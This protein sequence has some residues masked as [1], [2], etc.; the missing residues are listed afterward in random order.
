[1]Y[2]C[3]IINVQNMIL[4]ILLHNIDFSEIKGADNEDITSIVFDS[5]KSISGSLF[6]AIK[7]TVTDGHN[8]VQNA[9][10]SG[11]RAV[12]CERLP[13]I[14]ADGVTYVVVENSEKAVAELARAFYGDPSRKLKLVGVTGTNGKTTVA[15]LL[16][17][18]FRKLGYKV[19]LISTVVYKINDKDIASTHTTPDVVRLNG[20]FSEMVAEGC[21][22]CF[23]EVSSHSIVQKRV[24]SLDFDGAVFTNITHDHLDYHGTFVEYIR[25]KKELFDNLKKEAF[26]LYNCDDRNGEVMVQNCRAKKYSY[27]LSS[28][29]DFRCDVLESHFEGTLMEIDGQE[30]WSRLIGDFNAYNILS[31]YA[32]AKLLGVNREELLTNISSLTTVDGRFDY[33]T[34]PEGVTAIVDYAHTPDALQNVLITVNKIKSGSQKLICVVGC[35]GDRDKTKRPEMA[36]IAVKNSDFTIFTS[37]N[38][39]TEKPDDILAD[40]VVGVSGNGSFSSCYVTISDRLQAIKMASVMAKS[41][42]IILIAGKGHETYQDI[43]GVKNHFSDKEEISKLFNLIN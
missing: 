19:G 41:G 5:R 28:V 11:C 22:Y 1:M 20:M 21:E 9:V 40:M 6:V 13:E 23:M 17:Q 15:T 29:A 25:A 43:C 2:I 33:I 32:T 27:A 36:L 7:G 35:G 37:D 18:L 3:V 14:I 31:I 34:S 42:D 8:F 10:E 12:V 38:P 4:K 39:R 30:V 16:Y 26:A 24:W